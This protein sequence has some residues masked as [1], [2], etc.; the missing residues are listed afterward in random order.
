[1]LYIPALTILTVFLGVTL[2]DVASFTWWVAES[3]QTDVGKVGLVA[4]ANYC[5][6]KVLSTMDVVE[7]IPSRQ[8]AC[9][10]GEGEGK[11]PGLALFTKRV[12]SYIPRRCQ[13]LPSSCLFPE[14][15]S[16]LPQIPYV[17][18]Y[19]HLSSFSRLSDSCGL[20]VA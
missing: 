12:I 9:Q 19:P 18:P 13:P 11:Q 20:I 3:R 16:I 10:E 7:W 8:V 6:R 2:F 15:S 14:R 17:Y 5:L 1:M 4:E